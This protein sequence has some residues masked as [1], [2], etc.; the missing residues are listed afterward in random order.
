MLIP[1]LATRF[2][3]VRYCR[4][5]GCCNARST[6]HTRAAS[7]P[8]AVQQLCHVRVGVLDGLDG[9]TADV[10]APRTG[11]NLPRGVQVQETGRDA[12]QARAGGAAIGAPLRRRKVRKIAAS[13]ES[14]G[15]DQRP[16]RPGHDSLRR[17]PRRG[18]VGDEVPA[19]LTAHT[20]RCATS[21]RMRSGSAPGSGSSG[22]EAR[23]ATRCAT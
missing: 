9:G 14:R 18:Q 17:C 13:D 1:A 5:P 15:R 11:A 12:E 20:T 6:I 8:P 19:A 3:Q 23:S 4:R 22:T 7:T 10:G 16:A 21:A 2:F